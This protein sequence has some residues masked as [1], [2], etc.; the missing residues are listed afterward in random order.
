[1]KKVII[2]GSRGL[3]GTTVTEGL[4]HFYNHTESEYEIIE[5]DLSLGHDLTN[6]SFVKKF[7]KENKADCL[8]NLF[9]L[10]HH[11]DEGYEK[12]SSNLMEIDL[13]EIRKY[14]E[15]NV[16]ALTSCCREFIRNNDNVKNDKLSII[17]FGSLYSL[18]SPRTDIYPDDPKHIG[19]VV[20]KHAVVGLT[21]YIATHFAHKTRCN[22]ICPGGVDNPHIDPSFKKEYCKNVPMGRMAEASD[23]I[24]LVHLLCSR[25]SKYING[26]IIP[27]DGGWSAW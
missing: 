11:I 12:T 25:E 18:Q 4:K 3:I 2:T 13:E 24:G 14:N 7:F 6:E 20:S 16:V 26:T 27:I 21:K 17:N 5:C 19:Y 9:G 15:I 8:V 10:N 22:A 1:M 23:I